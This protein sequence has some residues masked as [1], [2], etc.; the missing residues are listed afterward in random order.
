M[1]DATPVLPPYPYRTPPRRGPW[2]WLGLGC[3]GLLLVACLLAALPAFAAGTA[4]NPAPAAQPARPGG[5]TGSPGGAAQG[6]TIATRNWRLTVTDVSQTPTLVWNR[7]GSSQAAVGLWLLVG[8]DLE[9]I[10]G[11]NFG[12]NRWDF[13]VHDSEGRVYRH[14]DEWA[15]L[16]Y[17][18]TRGALAASNRQIPPG[19]TAPLILVFDINP[20]ATG[21]QLVFAQERRPRADLGR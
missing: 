1:S 16:Q 9:N 19:T 20:D 8:V 15:A 3:G 12:V 18:D 5:A 11:E 7:W 2:R 17:P 14:T 13:E 10:G 21:L 4:G 6:A